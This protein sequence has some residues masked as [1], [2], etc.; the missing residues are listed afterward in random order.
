MNIILNRA[1]ATSFSTI[2]NRVLSHLGHRDKAICRF[3][4]NFESEFKK[5]TNEPG[6]S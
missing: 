4:F 2:S 3:L 1:L 6:Y 5:V